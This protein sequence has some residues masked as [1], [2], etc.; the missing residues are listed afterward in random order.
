VKFLFWNI[1]GKPLGHLVRALVD[2]HDIDV[3]ILAEWGEDPWQILNALN[4]GNA[5]R[6]FHT[7]VFEPATERRRGPPPP[8]VY[9]RFDEDAVRLRRNDGRA[10]YYE[11]L[12]TAGRSILLVAVHLPGRRNQS[13]HDQVVL[14]TRVGGVIRE[15]EKQLGHQQ[16]LVIGDFNMNPFDVGI[17][18][19]DA[20]HAVMTQETAL[21]RSRTVGEVECAF[22]YNPMWGH[23]G[24]RTP[25]PPGTYYYDSPRHLPL[26]WNTF[27]QVLLRPDLL[28][29]FD[30]GSLRIIERAGD[31]ALLDPR[32]G[33]PNHREASDHLPILF[34][35]DLEGDGRP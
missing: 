21:R 27:D 6:L 23:L 35:L 2:E 13:E 17:M 9:W 8:R 5:Q 3:V 14:A 12:T 16:T 29:V 32:S 22:F 19:S 30:G 1:Q 20:F 26:F 28:D 7:D 10:K 18:T 25:G 15:E 11:L 31:V 24:D 34:S 4:Q 33:R